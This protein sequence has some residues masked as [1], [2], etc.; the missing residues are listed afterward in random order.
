[1]VQFQGQEDNDQSCYD[2]RTSRM[3]VD[4]TNRQTRWTRYTHKLHTH[5]GEEL[6]DDKGLN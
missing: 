4:V 6:G 5:D 2:N 1:M 3:N